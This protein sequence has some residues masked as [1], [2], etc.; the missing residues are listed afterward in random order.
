[1]PLFPP[2]FRAAI[3]SLPVTILAGRV[4]A[5]DHWRHPNLGPDLPLPDLFADPGRLVPWIVAL[6]LVTGM[7]VTFGFRLRACRRSLRR[8][9]SGLA[10][11]P[12]FRAVDAMAHAVWDGRRIDPERLRRAVELAR[13]MTDMDYD[14]DR[15]RRIALR[16]DRIILPFTFRWMRDGLTHDEKLAIFNATVSVMLASGRL[17]RTDRFLLKTLSRGLGLRRDDLRDLKRLI[18]A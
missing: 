12:R 15:L 5:D 4:R 17:R 8:S 3:L 1:M 14:R 9:L 6:V 7:A 2:P 11:G 16:V 18:P 10:N 13:S